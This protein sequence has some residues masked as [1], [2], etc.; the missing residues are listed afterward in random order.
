ML[1]FLNLDL[2]ISD[3]S[4]SHRFGREMKIDCSQADLYSRQSVSKKTH[5]SMNTRK[6]GMSFSTISSVRK[7]EREILGWA[8]KRGNMLQ[9]QTGER[10]VGTNRV[11]GVLI[12]L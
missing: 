4:Q 3:L 12:K 7:K 1:Q 9:G 10:K 11:K 6:S 5:L 8:T 2:L